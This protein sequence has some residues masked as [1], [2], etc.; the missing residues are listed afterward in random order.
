MQRVFRTMILLVLVLFLQACTPESPPVSLPGAGLRARVE[1][2]LGSQRADLLPSIGHYGLVYG[3]SQGELQ[4]FMAQIFLQRD[5]SDIV[6]AAEGGIELHGGGVLELISTLWRPNGRS[7]ELGDA[8]PFSRS[9]HAV[10][11]R[12]IYDSMRIQIFL[13]VPMTGGNELNGQ[14]PVSPELPRMRVRHR[15]NGRLEEAELD[16]YN[17]LALLLRYEADLQMTWRNRFGQRISGATLLES[18]WDHYVIPRSPEEEFSDHSYLH[19]VELLLAYHRRLDVEARRDPNVLKRRLLSVELERKE[20]GGYAASE[21]LS[22]Y[23]ESLGFLLAE[24]GIRWTKTEKEKV[25]AWLRDL[26]TVRL[27]EIDKAPL[28]H[29]AHLLRGLRRIEA[30]ADR[31]R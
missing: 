11:L 18:A 5:G 28:Q 4:R 23:V 12:E 10:P 14:L 30:N 7:A 27:V 15:R 22:H 31:L 29:L 24:P 20:Y 21:A 19:L 3:V 9:E 1:A 16:A 6:M 26:E 2:R 17:A 13:P 25:L 8:F